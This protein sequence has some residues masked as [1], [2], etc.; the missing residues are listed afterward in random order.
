MSRI[1]ATGNFP[2]GKLNAHDE[3]ELQMAI[4]HKDGKILIQFGKPIAW[5]GLGP[6]HARQLAK[7][8]KMHADQAERDYQ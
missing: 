2:E 7:L 6:E 3:G 8:L 4:A 1:G 5:L